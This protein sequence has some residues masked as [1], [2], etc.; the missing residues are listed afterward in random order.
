[1]VSSIYIRAYTDPIFSGCILTPPTTQFQCDV[2]ASPTTGFAIGS[3]GGVTYNGNGKFY[4]CPVNDNGEYNV[5][6][7]PAPGQTKCV[8][9][10]LSSVGSCGAGGASASNT[11]T[12]KPSQTPAQSQAS[13]YPTSKPSPQPSKPAPQP[14]KPAPQP[15]QPAPQPPQPPVQTCPGPVTVTITVPSL[16]PSAPA[17]SA[18]APAPAPKPSGA[19]PADLNG[20]QTLGAAY[21]HITYLLCT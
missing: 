20:T 10:S 5:Y 11:P 12:P 2:G 6:S 1:V 15:S 4:A 18:P 8:E 9:I 7:T 3:G 14:S 16:A 21:V 19:C 17:P 13:G